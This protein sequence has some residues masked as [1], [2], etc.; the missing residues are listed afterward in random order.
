MVKISIVINSDTRPGIVNHETRATGMFDGCKSVDF[1]I[2]GVKNKQKFFE[3]YDTETI[4]FIDE[5]EQLHPS[6]VDEL[7]EMVDVLVI[8]KH[9]HE[10]HFNDFNYMAALQLARGE[11]IA[12]FDQDCAAF[13]GSSNVIEWHLEM[14]DNACFVS[15]PSKDSPLPVQDSSFDHVWVSTRFFMCRKTLL[16]FDEMS[17]CVRH[18]NYTFSRYPATRKCHWLE[19][20]IGLIAKDRCNPIFYPPFDLPNYAIFCWGS[21]KQGTLAHLNEMPYEQVRKWIEDA[22]G[23]HYPCDINIV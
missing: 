12:H 14:C 1:L 18:Y 20:I 7:R 13:R 17:K 10:E 4:L 11:Y 6:I 21:Y 16:H 8:R 15:Y 9:T 19:H 23:V 5:H 22:G 2:E 3:G